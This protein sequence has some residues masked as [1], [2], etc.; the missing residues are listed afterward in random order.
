MHG[1]HMWLHHSPLKVLILPRV[2]HYDVMNI[3]PESA[4]NCERQDGI[5][6]IPMWETLRGP[7]W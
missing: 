5:N 6:A 4:L 2:K 1:I 7:S 3:S